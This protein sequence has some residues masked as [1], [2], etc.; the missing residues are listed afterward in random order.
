MDVNNPELSTSPIL[1]ICGEG[2]ILFG[3]K[4]FFSFFIVS[5]LLIELHSP[6]T[7]PPPLSPQFFPPN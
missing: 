5:Y 6:Q 7:P 3:I 4:Y 2:A 1:Y